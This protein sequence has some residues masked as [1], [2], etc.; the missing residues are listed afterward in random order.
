[1][2]NKQEDNTETNNA[3]YSFKSYL[4]SKG[5]S[6]TKFCENAGISP[7]TAVKLG[8]GYRVRSDVALKIYSA[9]RCEIP[10][11]DISL[12]DTPYDRARAKIIR[13]ELHQLE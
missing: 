4:R 6:L 8:K 7:A 13:L 9:T 3:N 11:E 2:M 10:F 1:M 5:I 12:T